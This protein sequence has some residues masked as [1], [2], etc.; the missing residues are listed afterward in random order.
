M[1]LET[2][3]ALLTICEG[4]PLVT[5]WFPSQRPVTRSIDVFFGLRLNKWLSKQSRRRWFETPLRS[6]WRHRNVTPDEAWLGYVLR[7]SIEQDQ[8]CVSQFR[9]IRK[10]STP[11]SMTINTTE[12]RLSFET[13]ITNRFKFDIRSPHVYT[14]LAIT[15]HDDFIAVKHYRITGPLAQRTSNVKLWWF[16]L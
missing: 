16:N 6:L 5:G 2:F 13:T 7:A 8:M 1:G 10:V 15:W 4:N 9:K 11:Y 14:Y 12:Q 3:S